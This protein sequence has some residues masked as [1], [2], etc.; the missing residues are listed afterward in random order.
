MLKWSLHSI[1]LICEALILEMSIN[2]LNSC[3]RLLW[4]AVLK[5]GIDKV[6]QLEVGF[7]SRNISLK[8]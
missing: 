5:F 4:I 1:H 7:V 8:V 2:G 6:P 3:N